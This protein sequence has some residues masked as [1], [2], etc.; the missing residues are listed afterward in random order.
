MVIFLKAVLLNIYDKKYK[1]LMIFSILLLLLSL[2]VLSYNYFTKGELVE[3]GVSLKGGV[4]LTISIDQDLSI[5]SV[6]QHL[7]ND[8][9]DSDISLRTITEQGKIREIIIEAADLEEKQL[10]DSLKNHGLK[11]ERNQYSFQKTSSATGERFFKQTIIALIFA[12]LA[13][14]IVVFI[15]FRDLVP[16]LFVILTAFSDMVSTLAVI[17]LLDVKL[18]LGGVAAFLMMIGYSVDTDILLT[19]RVLKRKEG[20][21]FERTVNSLKTGLT[22]SLTSFFGVL[23]AYFLTTSDAIKQIMLILSIGFLFDIIYTWIQNTGILRWYLEIKEK[24]RTQQTK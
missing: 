11:I 19:T 4:E 20:T 23:A 21:I 1:Q 14:G 16:S 9:K 15:T 5:D 12:F 17:S 18:S 3:R 2:G 13:I 10:I 7:N 24:R 8:F 6:K 22:M